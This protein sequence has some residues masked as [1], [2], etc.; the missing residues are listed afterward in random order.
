MKEDENKKPALK[1]V[2][3]IKQILKTSKIRESLPSHKEDPF[4]LSP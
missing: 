1:L 2:K 4:L 3:Q